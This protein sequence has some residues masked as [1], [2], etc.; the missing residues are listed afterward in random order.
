[1]RKYLL[2]LLAILTI[3]CRQDKIEKKVV[4]SHPYYDQAWKLLD[5]KSVDS[6]FLYFNKAKEQFLQEGDSVM[7][8]KCLINMAIISGQRGDYFGSQEISISAIDY[9]ASGSKDQHEL[10]SSNYNCLGNMSA[11]LKHFQQADQFY[12]QALAFTKNENS[13]N[14]ILNNLGISLTD[15]RV[16]D[17]ALNYFNRLLASKTIK[18]NPVSFSRI[19]SNTAKTKWL[20]NPGYNPVPEFLTALEIRQKENDLWGQNAS[21]AHLADFYIEQKPDSALF[22][23]Q[24]MYRVAQQLKS[25]DDQV[26]ALER[27]IKLSSPG[28]FREHFE[29]Y[30]KLADSLEL[31]RNAAKNQFA[32]IRYETE[33]NKTNNL[34]LL[35]ENAEKKY[36]IGRQRALLYGFLM[37]IISGSV[38]ALIWYR[39]RK[40][41]LELEAKATIREHELKIHKKVHDVVANGLYRMMS[42]IENQNEIN[43]EVVLDRIELLYE[44]S[45][46]ITY[47]EPLSEHNF[48]DK[49]SSLLKSFATDQIKIISAGNNSDLWEK[50]NT[51]AKNEIEHVLQ[52]LMVNMR[53]HS[54]AENV[55]IRFTQS[56]DKINIYYADDGIGISEDTP[57][58][59]GLKNTGN[60]IKS[61]EGEIKF[62]GH[63]NEG[64]KIHISF[65]IT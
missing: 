43:K 19:L 53:K 22:Y 44:K 47:E 18:E 57:F 49:I 12:R 41:K 55:V 40:Q 20:Q 28:Q 4:K 45:R 63:G 30:R 5:E 14:T 60:R 11:R 15:Q 36:Q 24:R 3:S 33:K 48:Q 56:N 10:L 29:V 1:M 59:N 65:P 8:A 39:K 52:E 35:K 38:T 25:A 13:R 23:A 32:L 58:N 42:E 2:I 17:Q 34:K 21:F 31:D 64:L 27:I 61:I 46:D 50:V 26:Y 7:V 51:V 16:Y 9:L 6:S 54:N 62:D 37:V